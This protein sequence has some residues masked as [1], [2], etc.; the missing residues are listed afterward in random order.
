MGELKV[1]IFTPRPEQEGIHNISHPLD[2]RGLAA[3]MPNG[4]FQLPPFIP[5]H[6]LMINFVKLILRP[7]PPPIV[8]YDSIPLWLTICIV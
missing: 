2:L 6:P 3:E 8:L 7:C 4:T 1:D 5:F